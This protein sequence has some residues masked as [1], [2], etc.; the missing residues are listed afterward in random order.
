MSR[1]ESDA[2][3]IVEV[4]PRDGLQNE[5]IAV[6]LATKLELI[7]RLR[8][9]GVSSLEATSF[10]NPAAVPQLADAVD[11]IPR[12][13][14]SLFQRVI[15]LVPNERGYDRARAAGA[16]TLEVFAAATDAF[17]QAN[18]RCSVED[19]FA[20]FAPVLERASKDGINVRGAV[21]VAFVCPFSG[22][23]DAAGALA[24]AQRLLELGCYE[25]AIC[26]TIGRA[27]DRQ[28]E[29]MLRIL[30]ERLPV[31]RV[32]LH[33]HDT[34]GLAVAHVQRGY[35]AGIRVFDS[36]VGGLGG[37]PFAPGAPGNVATEALVRHFSDSGIETGL[38][39]DRLVETGTWIRTLL[40]RPAHAA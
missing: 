26:D 16:T 7:D 25:V 2:V 11:L 38:D 24:V 6:D 40:G 36:A 5:P 9:A 21:S 29:T 28:V 30:P 33:M 34:T 35:E 32:A 14:Q 19:S 3:T 13:D 4:G 37:C 22:D 15:A 10:V 27:T 8:A 31:D 39:I 1:P 17:S 18:I 23:V 20:R 12:I